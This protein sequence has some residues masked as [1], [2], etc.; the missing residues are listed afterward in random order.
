MGTW[1]KAWLNRVSSKGMAISGRLGLIPAYFSRD[2]EFPITLGHVLA[3]GIFKPTCMQIGPHYVTYIKNTGSLEEVGIRDVDI[4]LFWPK[5]IDHYELYKSCT[6]CLAPTHWHHYEVPETS[7]DQGESVVDCGAAE[8]VFALSV[9]RRAGK[10]AIFEPWEGFRESLQRTFGDRAV[11]RQQALGKQSCEAYLSGDKLYG[12]VNGSEGAR[13][14]VTTLDD[15]RL[16]FGPIN[17]IKADVEGSEHDL[18]QGAQATILAD[19]PKIAMTCYHEQNDWRYMLKLLRRIV[20][21]Y[22]YRVKGISYNGNK[23]RPVMLHTWV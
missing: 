7:V 12:V 18:L 17:F 1:R 15:F 22:K 13:I 23:V 8:G 19:K 5:Q 9:L 16:E 14:S 10:V 20:P 3:N 6:D 11:I 4:P 21:A 2:R